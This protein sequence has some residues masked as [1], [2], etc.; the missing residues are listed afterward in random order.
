MKG[1][2]ERRENRVAGKTS[3]NGDRCGREVAKKQIFGSIGAAIS[4]KFN[5][6]PRLGIAFTL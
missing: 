6:I 3:A 5:L 4:A 2:D 1:R